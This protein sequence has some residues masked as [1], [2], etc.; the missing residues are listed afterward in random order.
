MSRNIFDKRI[1]TLYDKALQD[2]I[3]LHFVSDGQVITSK[4][5][6]AEKFHF[7]ISLGLAKYY[8]DAIS[9]NV[10]RAHEQKLRKGEWVGKAPYSYL[11]IKTD[12]GKKQLSLMNTK[13]VSSKKH[14]NSTQL[15]HSL[16]I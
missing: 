16:S 6:A 5:S 8:S 10:K 15:E 2:K 7:G 3:E 14:I 13:P 12:D 9:D 1:S 4:I 11:N